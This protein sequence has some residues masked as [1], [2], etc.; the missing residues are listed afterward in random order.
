MK[1]SITNYASYIA[2]WAIILQIIPGQIFASSKNKIIYPLKEISKLECRFQ[3]FE[4]LS[5]KCKTNLPILHSKD[6]NKYAT[7]NGGYNDFTR[8]Y[9]VL[10]GSSYKY[11]WDVG[12][13]WHQGTDIATAKGTPVYSIADGT[14]IESGNGIGWGNYISIEHTIHGKK[15][16]SNYAHLATR[17]VEKWDTVSVWDK[18]GWVGS[19]WNSTGNHLHFQIDLPSEFHPYYYDYQKCP[20]GY[21]TITEEWVCFDELQKNTYDPLVFLENNWVV[22]HI[23]QISIQ[24]DWTLDE[25]KKT[26]TQQNISTQTEENPQNSQKIIYDDSIFS[27]SLSPETGTQDEIKEIQ[28][29]YNKLGY[30]EGSISGEYDD[31]FES[32]VA[33]QLNTW[34]ISS[35]E[36][37]WAWWFGP[38]TRAQTQIDYEAYVVSW[39]QS[40]LQVSQVSQ[41]WENPDREIDKV[42]QGVSRKNLMT[43]EEREEKAMKDF[44]DDYT[45]ELQNLSKEISTNTTALST[46]TLT[47]KKGKAF[48]GNTPWLVNWNYNSEVLSVFPES[49]YN[50]TDGTREI[51]IFGINVGTTTLELRIWSVVIESYEITVWETQWDTT[52]EEAKIYMPEEATLWDAST[53]IVLMKDNWGKKLI[54]TPYEGNFHIKSDRDI[55]YCIKRGE[56]TDI[57]SIY[58][59]DC[60]PEE[61]TDTLSFDYDDTIAGLL[62]FDYQV[63]ESWDTHLTLSQ[64]NGKLLSKDVLSIEAEESQENNTVAQK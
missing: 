44:A 14:V 52:P 34:V 7:K 26:E 45:I 42:T 22:E 63:E 35:R 21:Y 48:R 61:F 5:A 23:E 37:L 43:R 59:R 36:D 19:T 53:A 50:F 55:S 25:K 49:F 33:Y 4:I 58:L 16:I 60:Y 64:A 28:R 32:I 1:K 27:I 57:K 47:N 41:I 10:W 3:D 13:G 40:I 2:L 8:I 38:K 39:G 46:L 29:I 11:G 31:V 17:D 20:Y 51:Q 24:E 6:Y 54:N 18:I 12:Y 62:I 56:L 15:I 9:T 30:Y